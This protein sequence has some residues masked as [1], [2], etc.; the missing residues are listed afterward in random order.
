MKKLIFTT[1]LIIQS[2]IFVFG[3]TYSLS[4]VGGM[5]TYAGTYNNQKLYVSNLGSG[6]TNFI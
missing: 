3:Y 2:S 5:V 6:Y 1:I 4:A